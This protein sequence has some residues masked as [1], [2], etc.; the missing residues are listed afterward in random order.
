MG[1][2]AIA[3]CCHP[4]HSRCCWC[5]VCAT[6]VIYYIE[7]KFHENQ[8][9]MRWMPRTQ[10]LDRLL[11]SG[12]DRQHNDFF[13]DRITRPLYAPHLLEPELKTPS[14]SFRLFRCEVCN[15]LV[16]SRHN[17]PLNHDIICF[18]SYLITKLLQSRTSSVHWWVMAVLQWSFRRM[19]RAAK[20]NSRAHHIQTQTTKGNDFTAIR[21]YNID[22]DEWWQKIHLIWTCRTT[23]ADEYTVE[24]DSIGL[25]ACKAHSIAVE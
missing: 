19:V 3:T 22:A 24:M 5:C 25:I 17:K 8:E 7:L 9:R 16:T 2:R 11:T 21:W 12:R 13:T 6:N 20:H 15:L 1:F 18:V 10:T 14:Y 23:P 4:T